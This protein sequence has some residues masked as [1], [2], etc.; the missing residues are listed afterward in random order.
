MM[1]LE[2]YFFIS[3]F[4]KDCGLENDH[5]L[6]KTKTTLIFCLLFWQINYYCSLTK[7][8]VEK[9]SS[10]APFP[11]KNIIHWGKVYL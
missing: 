3:Y 4:I 1:R 11:S 5:L 2:F 10:V 8:S 6:P 9:Q 7:L